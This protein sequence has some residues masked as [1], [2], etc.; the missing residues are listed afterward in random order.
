VKLSIVPFF[1]HLLPQSLRSRLIALVLLSVLAG[2]AATLYALS[3]FQRDYIQTVALDLVATT[4]RT[5]QFSMELVRPKDRAAYVQ[6]ASQGEW[7]L[8]SKPLPDEAQLQ[9]KKVMKP[10][11]L[12]R[13]KEMQHQQHQRL[14][15]AVGLPL[16]HKPPTQADAP[17]ATPLVLAGS[18]LE[19]TDLLLP[20]V[21][22]DSETYTANQTTVQDQH[23]S[24]NIRRSLNSFIQ[25]LNN[26]LDGDSRVAI[27]RGKMPELYISLTRMEDSDYPQVQEWLVIPLDQLDPPLTTQMLALWAGGLALV[28]LTALWFSWH[29]SRPITS[30]VQATDQLAA[31]KPARV[32][33]AGPAETRLLGER[34]NAML[35]A[36]SHSE[37]TRRTLLAGLPHDLKAPLARMWLRIEMTDDQTLKQGMRTDLKDMQQMVDQF[38][39][40]LRGT[41][42]ASYHFAPFALNEWVQERVGNWQGTGEEVT[43]TNT[44]HYLEINADSVALS[45]LLD[46]LVSNALHHGKPPVLVSLSQADGWAILTV[47]DHGPG[48]A[49]EDRDDALRPFVRLDSARTR[50]GNVGLGLALAEAIAQAHG[51]G[52]TLGQGPGGGLEIKVRLPIHHPV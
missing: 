13:Q 3:L 31:G 46:N 8:W 39:H 15:E 22:T 20:E 45:R 4:I 17:G 18:A 43:L 29:I 26:R 16:S 5:L 7:Q 51:G 41:D 1:K 24:D 27:S 21:G 42:R 34:F 37:S 19:D 38:I 6:H 30:L 40:F 14:L 28:L 32:E 23:A 33:P 49:P 12:A 2:Q 44:P 48:I 50:T 10:Q 52:L 36:L 47:S 11:D 9:E 35:D 25:R